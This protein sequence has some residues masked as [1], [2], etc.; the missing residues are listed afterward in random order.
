MYKKGL[1]AFCGWMLPDIKKLKIT[2][3]VHVA[4]G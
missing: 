4:V 2:R 3:S 1:F